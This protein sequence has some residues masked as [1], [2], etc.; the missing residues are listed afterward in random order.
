MR[1][2]C[3]AATSRTGHHPFFF[4]T[5]RFSGL[6]RR[7]QNVQ[8]SSGECNMYNMSDCLSNQVSRGWLLEYHALTPAYSYLYQSSSQLDPSNTRIIGSCTGLLAAVAASS[9]PNLSRLPSLGVLLVRIAFR[10]GLLVASTGNRLQ[11]S[12]TDQCWSIAVMGMER[13][14]MNELL[15][16][17]NST[18]VRADASP[19]FSLL[20]FS[21][22]PSRWRSKPI[23]APSISTR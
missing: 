21:I 18:E 22:R 20:T 5:L 17:F 10:A 7:G 2:G 3:S 11:Q 15:G 13:D 8:S 19:W 1:G 6:V 9:S 23:S 12:S 14:P 4:D 16:Q